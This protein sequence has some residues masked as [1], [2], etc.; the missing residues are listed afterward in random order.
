MEGALESRSFVIWKLGKIIENSDQLA[1]V[2]QITQTL[3]IVMNRIMNCTN[4]HPSGSK[5]RII[6]LKRTRIIWDEVPTMVEIEIFLFQIHITNGLNS[7]HRKWHT[8]NQY[9]VKSA[10]NLKRS[11]LE[12]LPVMNVTKWLK[13]AVWSSPLHIYHGTDNIIKQSFISSSSCPKW[14]CLWNWDVEYRII[15]HRTGCTVLHI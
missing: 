6:C 7:L 12:L 13:I 10:E 3:K 15:Q 1:V 5:S 11:N 9:R 14:Y 8:G 2:K 4:S